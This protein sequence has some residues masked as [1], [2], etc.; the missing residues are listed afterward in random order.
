MRFEPDARCVPHRHV[1]PTRTLVIE[2]EHRIYSAEDGGRTLEHARAAGAFATNNGDETHIEGGGP[3]G[4][5]I[6]LS[7]SGVDSVVYEIFDDAMAL[8]RTIT[9][10]DFKRGLA[11]QATAA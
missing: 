8:Q 11:K 9:L 4:A 1:G 6:L 5:V 2:G 10:D 7:M 3:E